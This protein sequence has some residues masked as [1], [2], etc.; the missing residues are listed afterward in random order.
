MMLGIN[1]DV[2]VAPAKK[3]NCPGAKF[4]IVGSEE[5]PHRGAILR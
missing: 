5:L 4:A 1:S 3:K 2:I